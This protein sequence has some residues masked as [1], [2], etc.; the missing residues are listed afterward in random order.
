VRVWRALR[1]RTA[2]RVAAR[3][4]G[5][6][7]VSQAVFQCL[8]VARQSLALLVLSVHIVC[9]VAPAQLAMDC[10]CLVLFLFLVVVLM[11]A[12]QIVSTTLTLR[13]KGHLLALFAA[14][15]KA[16]MRTKG[17]PFAIEGSM[18]P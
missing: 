11:N 18:I 3:R 15:R 6:V 17:P 13:F 1:G 8:A 9:G 5:A 2:L 4:A 7:F 16:N 14:L 10:V 12:A